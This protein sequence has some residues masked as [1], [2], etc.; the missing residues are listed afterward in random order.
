MDRDLDGRTYDLLWL[1]DRHEP[2][3]SIRLVELMRRHGYSI[4]GRTIRLTLA[5]LDEAGLTE[6]V[7]GQGRRLTAAGRTEL[8]RGNVSSRLDHVRSRIATLRSRVTYDPLE[9]TGV[10]LVSSALVD[11]ADLDPA[12]EAIRSLH[13]SPLGPVPAAIEPVGDGADR[14]RVLVPSSLTLDGVLLSHGID[15]DLRTAGV[16]AYTPPTARPDR[17][18]D[19][20]AG[21]AA[22]VDVASTDADGSEDGDDGE[23]DGTDEEG[24]FGGRIDRY[25][26]V[27][28]GEDASVDVLSLLIEAGRT[29]TTPIL[30]EGDSG[31]LAVD[32]REFPLTR[33]SEARDLV[34]ATRDALGGVIDV[35]R[36]REGGP[37]PLGPPGWEFGAATYGGSGE[38]AIAVLAER[39][40]SSEWDTL[41]DTIDR[42]RLRPAD[43]LE[44][45]GPFG[46]DR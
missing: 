20:E 29:D 18:D 41:Y 33:Y 37:F 31:V 14:H 46:D 28:S 12:L 40:L 9:D 24:R 13:T 3:G 4:T 23:G 15:T 39:G 6:K 17:S 2:V 5:D 32:Y 45:D 36:P 35:R 26:D 8:E 7:P 16:V 44:T 1:V 42:D 19:A 25:V 43:R 22:D 21:G 38:L 27:I 10:L 11:T 34:V 30:E